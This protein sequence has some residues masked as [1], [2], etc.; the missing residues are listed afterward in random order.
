[1]TEIHLETRRSFS[2]RSGGVAWSRQTSLNNVMGWVIVAFVALVPIPFGSGR[3][4]FWGVNAVFVGL[5]GVAYATGLYHLREPFRHSMAHFPVSATLYFVF[6]LYLLV[7]VTPLELVPFVIKWLPNLQIHAPSGMTL[8]PD[9]ISLAPGATWLM[10]LRWGT[11]GLF[12]F[13]VLQIAS[14]ERRRSLLLHSALMIISAYGIFGLASLLQFGDTVLGLPKWAYQGSATATFVNRNSFATFLA[15]GATLGCA[16]FA[17]ALV[18]QLP[19]TG[20]APLRRNLDPT[21]LFYPVALAAIVPT[22]LA[23]Q[24]RMGTL[25]A[26]VGCLVV[27]VTALVRMPKLWLRALMLVPAVIVAGALT[28]FI[29]G[30]DLLERLGSTATSSDVRLELYKQII[31]MIAARPWLGYGGG[32]FELVYPLFHQLPVSPDLVWERAHNSYLALWA[33][34]G[35]V[36]GSIPILLLAIVLVRILGGIGAA[37]RSW[38][39]QA[40]GLGVVTVGAVHSLVDFS[41]EIQANTILLLFITAIATAGAM[42]NKS[43]AR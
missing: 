37:R 14:N 34:L 19:A 27:I 32:S 9:R 29:F 11:F 7:Q 6:M 39:A 3:P 30:Q 31:A 25:S 15:F 18:R 41:L 42:R 8:A 4:F 21:L 17:G 1:M 28:F 24:S 23:T 26:S 16:L 5:A 40:A 2:P 12:Y 13:L 33:E 35:V 22:L 10:L 20:E 36:I 43:S 38:G